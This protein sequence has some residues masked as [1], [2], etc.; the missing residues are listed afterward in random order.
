[1]KGSPKTLTKPQIALLS[2]SGG[3]LL[4]AAVLILCCILLERDRFSSVTVSAE[5]VMSEEAYFEKFYV[6]PPTTEPTEPPTEPITYEMQIDLQKVQSYHATNPDVIG[7]L[8][9]QDTPV[10]YPVVQ[11]TDN[12]FY[13]DHNWKKQYS[14]AGSIFADWQC[15]IES[16][17]NSLIYGHN[18]G[19][20]TM[21]HGIKYYKDEAWGLEHPFFEVATLDKR[22]LYEVISV[23]VIYGE[24]GA[25]FEYWKCIDMDE[26]AY[27]AFIQ[28]IRDTSYI[29]Y[30][31][32]E[33][34]PQYGRDRM[35]ALQT[36]NSGAHDGMRCVLFARC[37]GER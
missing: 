23:N 36:C 37:V 26:A 4:I 30:G 14:Y 1:M 18:M 35:I 15:R 21:L 20:G 22:Y 5:Q 2:V 29:W 28:N 13:M 7:W 17:E 25:K 3:L 10:N 16:S 6:P 12:Y 11:G 33:R 32:D 9:I 31:D 34:L 19:N 24:A 27:N 8:Y